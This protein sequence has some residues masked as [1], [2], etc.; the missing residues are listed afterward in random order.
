[1]KLRMY[2]RGFGLGIVTA[3]LVMSFGVKTDNGTI[4]DAEVRKRAYELGM[5]DENSTLAGEMPKTEETSEDAEAVEETVAEEETA[6]TSEAETAEKPEEAIETETEE[7]TEETAETETEDKSE[8]TAEPETVAEPKTEEKPETAG[9]PKTEEKSETA[10]KPEAEKK[11]EE[12][13]KPQPTSLVAKKDYTLTI[14]GGY[15][16]DRVARILEDAG[17]IDSASSFDKY[18]CDNRYDNRISVGTYKIPAG[19]DYATIAKMITHS[20]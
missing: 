2:L 6:S 15:S 3:A 5:V 13:P 9:E 19:A 14:V 8:E 10:A 11:T 7:N 17:V 20:N 18:L 1:M 16:S 12:Q 4:S